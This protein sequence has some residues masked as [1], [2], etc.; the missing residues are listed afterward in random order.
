MPGYKDPHARPVMITGFGSDILIMDSIRKP[1][2]LKFF[3][4]D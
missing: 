2:R 4:S 3:G 1:K